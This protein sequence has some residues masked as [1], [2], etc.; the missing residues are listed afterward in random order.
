MQEGQHGATLSKCRKFNAPPRDCKKAHWGAGHKEKSARPEERAPEKAPL[1]SGGGG[2]EG[3][4]PVCLGPLAECPELDLPRSHRFYAGCVE[5]AVVVRGKA[6]TRSCRRDRSSCIRKHTGSFLPHANARYD[7]GVMHR[8]SQGV[9]QK[10][11]EAVRWVAKAAAQGIPKAKYIPG[12][13]YT[14]DKEGIKQDL[15]SA[16]KLFRLAAA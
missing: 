6:A 2:D 9:P 7:L 5:G 13:L 14:N 12:A 16:L 1:A 10:F 15:P 8:D 4:C 11:K 3:E